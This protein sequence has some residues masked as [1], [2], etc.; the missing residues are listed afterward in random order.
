ME[1]TDLK[2]TI[3]RSSPSLYPEFAEDWRSML[4]SAGLEGDAV[5]AALAEG[6]TPMA[7]CGGV[8]LIIGG[9]LLSSAGRYWAGYEKLAE[10]A[11]C[12]LETV[13]RRMGALKR[14][15]LLIVRRRD[16]KPSIVTLTVP[17]IGEYDD[18]K[19]WRAESLAGR[20]WL[21]GVAI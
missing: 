12:S 21:Q 4:D 13:K 16:H 11:G 17:G 3:D 15:G 7:H 20:A 19:Q 6:C 10:D 1:F 9:E 14:A 8:A 5:V 18:W 2:T